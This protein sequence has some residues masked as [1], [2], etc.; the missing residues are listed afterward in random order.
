MLASHCFN[1]R[2]R[3]TGG[4]DMMIVNRSRALHRA[5]LSVLVVSTL[6]LGACG[7]GGGDSAASAPPSGDF[8]TH[9][10]GPST[11]TPAATGSATLSWM[12]PSENSDGTAL[13]D[14]RGYRIYAGRT[15]EELTAVATL[16]TPGLTRYVVENLTSGTWYFAV[17]SYASDGSESALSEVVSKTIA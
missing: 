14:L 4:Y 10:A 11:G 13:D 17:A 7:G 16:D 12:P 6:A 1:P 8:T 5:F 2:R 9:G 3:L 15:Q